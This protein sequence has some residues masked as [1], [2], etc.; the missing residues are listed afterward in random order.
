MQLITSFFS[1]CCLITDSFPK[2]SSQVFSYQFCFKETGRSSL[3]FNKQRHEE[4]MEE[5]KSQRCDIL[6][7]AWKRKECGKRMIGMCKATAP[8][9][10]IWSCLNVKA[11]NSLRREVLEVCSALVKLGLE[12]GR[13]DWMK[14]WLPG[15]PFSLWGRD[16]FA[17]FLDLYYEWKKRKW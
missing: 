4:Y 15:R 8:S 12:E 3:I 6:S 10:W 17:V 9:I 11:E 2:S 7:R 13:K 5:M 16:H 14:L 1:S